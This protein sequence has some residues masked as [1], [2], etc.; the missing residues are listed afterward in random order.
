MVSAWAAERG[1]SKTVLVRG[2]SSCLRGAY[3]VR[4]DVHAQVVHAEL[5]FRRDVQ[6]EHVFHDDQLQS[7]RDSFEF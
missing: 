6:V 2:R 4:L 5:A 1:S 7:E 3:V